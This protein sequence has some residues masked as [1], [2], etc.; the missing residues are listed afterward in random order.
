MPTRARTWRVATLAGLWLGACSNTAPT[1]AISTEGPVEAPS[2][3]ATAPDGGRTLAVLRRSG[4]LRVRLDGGR[5]VPAGE[6]LRFVEA[7]S[8]WS[9]V[10]P[11]LDVRLA[12][13]SDGALRIARADDPE[14]WIELVSSGPR[15]VDARVEGASA[16]YRDVAPDLDDA[17]VAGPTR[18]EQLRVV[19]ASGAAP[20]G[21]VTTEQ[22]VRF[23]P[24]VRAVRLAG[25][26]VE[27]VALDGS[28]AISTEPPTAVD[29]RGVERDVELALTDDALTTRVDVAA[30]TMPVVVDP[31]WVAGP[32]FGTYWLGEALP[33]AD[34]SDTL[35]LVGGIHTDPTGSETTVT[36]AWT[37]T[38]TDGFNPLKPMTLPRHG[39]AMVRIGLNF[40]VIG[41]GRWGAPDLASAEL[42]DPVFASWRSAGNMSIPRSKMS[43]ALLP[44]GKVLVAGGFSGSGPVSSAEIYDP[45]S[46]SWST[47]LP[48][49][50][51]TELG[52]AVTL[53]NGTALFVGGSTDRSD[54]PGSTKAAVY[55]ES[56]HTWTSVGDLATPRVVFGMI[57]LPSGK[58]IA[59]GGEHDSIHTDESEIFDPV[60]ATWSP[61]PKMPEKV[62]E[63]VV[64]ALNDGNALIVG[65]HG[66]AIPWATTS[67]SVYDV[68]S[69]AFYPTSPMSVGRLDPYAAAIGDGALVA[70]GLANPHGTN[71]TSE[72]FAPLAPGAACTLAGD[73]KSLHCVDG[74][75]CNSACADS[76]S[77]CDV[78]GN[79]GT[80]IAIVGKPHGPRACPAEAPICTTGGCSATS[81]PPDA[82]G[83]ATSATDAGMVADAAIDTSDG[84]DARAGD[85]APPTTTTRSFYGCATSRAPRSTTLGLVVA[86]VVAGGLAR[87][88][89]RR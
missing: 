2:P 72:R 36:S 14:L 42:Y 76:C 48:M 16:V 77:A 82:G 89:R 68:A 3:R 70:G 54:R 73:C 27:V 74:F 65:G 32:A 28:V 20:G 25:R 24:H 12:T 33:L 80:C 17:V 60:T 71:S 44:S 1:P 8:A 39:S 43:W 59:F 40:L 11:R 56:S 67:A 81:T 5:L 26:V 69:N 78:A 55:D 23:G 4:A 18:V 51:A 49:P 19:H 75:C 47:T 58:A 37:W 52:R 88:R 34:G 31:V 57:A 9:P 85:D 86:V 21:I 79:T 35:L 30:L 63:I 83:D 84:S 50:F 46:N 66:E 6:G 87:R 61:G 64:V 10:G 7:P 53:K 41:G 38:L 15:A 62:S 45:G 13:R 22:R 29:A